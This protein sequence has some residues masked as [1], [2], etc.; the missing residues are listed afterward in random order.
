MEQIGR[1][2]AKQAL[3]TTIES[4]L[5]SNTILQA[6]WAVIDLADSEL[7]LV[8]GDHPLHIEGPLREVFVI[9]LPLLPRLLF[10]ATNRPEILSGLRNESQTELVRETNLE[11]ITHA[12]KYVWACDDG[13]EDVIRDFLDRPVWDIAKKPKNDKNKKRLRPSEE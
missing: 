5:L 11:S 1:N 4:E 6:S 8:V 7:S 13:S 3:P 2:T 9:G 10:C 12:K